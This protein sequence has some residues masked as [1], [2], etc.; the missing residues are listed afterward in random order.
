MSFQ[1]HRDF[2]ETLKKNG[3]AI[4]VTKEVDWDLEAGAIGRRMYEMGGPSIWFKKVKDYPDGF[5]LY[6]GSLGT[7]RRVAISLGLPAETPVREIYRI[8][9]ERLEKPVDPI[10]VPPRALCRHA[11]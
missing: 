8:Y 3:D 9:E 10:V 2:I 6:N 7:W 11:R 4:E 1:D 5:T